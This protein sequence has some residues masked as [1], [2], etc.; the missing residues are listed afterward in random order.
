[1]RRVRFTG[2]ALA[3]VPFRI[4]HCHAHNFD[5]GLKLP[6][7]IVDAAANRAV[8]EQDGSQPAM[9]L[10]VVAIRR[11]TAADARR[12]AAID[13]SQLELD[14]VRLGESHRFVLHDRAVG[15][16]GVAPCGRGVASRPRAA[17]ARIAFV[18]AIHVFH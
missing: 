3:K 4:S 15:R 7:Q 2:N 14:R 16:Q 17:L 11:G 5:E 13:A 9:R 10:A 8:S 18:E 1:M 6:Q 12:L